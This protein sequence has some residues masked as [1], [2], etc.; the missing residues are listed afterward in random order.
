MF[1]IY[2]KMDLYKLLETVQANLVDN[3]DSFYQ[4]ANSLIG[5][6]KLHNLGFQKEQIKGQIETYFKTVI[7]NIIYKI[8]K[9]SVP[10]YDDVILEIL[11]EAIK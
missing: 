5:I 3:I 6:G 7:E 1:E 2:K 9:A 8:E 4:K 11:R 10:N